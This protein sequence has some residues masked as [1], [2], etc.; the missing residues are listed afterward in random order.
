MHLGN[1]QSGRKHLKSC[2]KNPEKGNNTKKG[3]AVQCRAGQ[4]RAK[5]F[6]I[7]TIAIPQLTPISQDSSA[8]ALQTILFNQEPP[9]KISYQNVSTEIL[10]YAC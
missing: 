1:G 5:M 3:Y 10:W 8:S 4:C 9:V 6:S 2:Q 7:A